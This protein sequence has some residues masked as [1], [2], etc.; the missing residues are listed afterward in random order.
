MEITGTYEELNNY[1]VYIIVDE[2]N[3]SK[4]LYLG[5]DRLSDAFSMVKFRR[6]KEFDINT[7]Y[8]IT[9]VESHNNIDSAYNAAETLKD[10]FQPVALYTTSIRAVRCKETGVVYNT[11][12]QATIALGL[13]YSALYNHLKGKVGFKTVKGLTFEYAGSNN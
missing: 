7:R 10:I 9:I 4:V 13:S 11:A 2:N 3:P 1:K 5:V 12:R 8:T 6:C